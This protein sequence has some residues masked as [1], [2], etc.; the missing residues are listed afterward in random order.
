MA[1]STYKTFLMP[2]G[3]IVGGH[4]DLYL[5]VERDGGQVSQSEHAHFVED[6]TLFKGTGRY[7]GAP[8]IAEGFVAVSISGTAPSATAV[9]FTQDKANPAAE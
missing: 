1:T 4:G 9:T 7:D 8:V 3:V 6:Q 2:D 5:L